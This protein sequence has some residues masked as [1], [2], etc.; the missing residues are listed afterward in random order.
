MN[1]V[2]LQ[3]AACETEICSSIDSSVHITTCFSWK[4]I[5]FQIKL[6]LYFYCGE[7]LMGWKADVEDL[8]HYLH[9]STRI[10]CI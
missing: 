3:K 9:T 7:I 5:H 1:K 2:T 10:T 8:C 6:Q 4:Q